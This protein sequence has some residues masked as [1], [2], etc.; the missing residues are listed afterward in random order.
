MTANQRFRPAERLRRGIDFD[1]VFAVRCT[2][3]DAL[4]AVH[5]APNALPCS[6]LGISVGRRIGNSVRRHYVRRRIRE[7]FRR[8][9]DAMPKGW[10]I[11]CVAR[12]RAGERGT[13]VAG[14]LCHLLAA[15]VRRHPGGVIHRPRSALPKEPKSLD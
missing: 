14:S 7:A 8:N 1:R 3:A 10:D 6:R 4:M 12:A 9:K 11:V 5:V 15:A 2:A 13:D